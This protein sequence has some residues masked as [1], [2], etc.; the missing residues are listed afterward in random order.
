MGVVEE[1]WRETEKGMERGVLQEGR[2]EMMLSAASSKVNW[3]L[4]DQAVTSKDGNTERFSIEQ[5]N[6]GQV[7]ILGSVSQA[8]DAVRSLRIGLTKNSV[9][10]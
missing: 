9:D 5:E 2:E 3:K 1:G 8:D 4:I 10:V 7:Q 6:R